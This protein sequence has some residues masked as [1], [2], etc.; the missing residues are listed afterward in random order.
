MT[1]TE[2]IDG[3][4]FDILE[5][6]ELM[7]GMRDME[8]YPLSFFSQTFDLAYKIIRDLHV[9]EGLQIDAFQRQMQQYQE[10]IESALL[11]QETI[12]EP[13]EPAVVAEP[14]KATAGKQVVSLNDALEKKN[15]SDLRKA[16]S[17]NDRFYFRQELF[18]GDEAKMNKVITDL[19]GLHSYEES[20]RYL[21][22]TQDWDM[23]NA[24][25]AGF[26]ALVEK[27]FRKD[28]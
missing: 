17:L 27:R 3:L 13:R 10:I 9:L 22:E 28:V 26:L 23:K 7:V 15:L 5:L 16:L 25:V 14:S 4:I 8:V 20:V 21:N 19:N 12:A 2:K 11:M 18:A 6:K 1:N 24:V